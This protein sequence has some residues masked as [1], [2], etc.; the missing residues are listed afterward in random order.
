MALMPPS[1]LRDCTT[2]DFRSVPTFT[3]DPEK[4]R[5]LMKPFPLGLLENET[6]G[7]FHIA[8]VTCFVREGS[9]TKKRP[10]NEPPQSI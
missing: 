7:G 3:I 6:G 9:L 1:L 8:D 2:R 4:Q 5:I 10:G